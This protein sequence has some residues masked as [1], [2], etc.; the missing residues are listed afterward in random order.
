MTL[1]REFTLVKTPVGGLRLAQKPITGDVFGE[2][3]ESD[4][5]PGELFRL[6]VR[7]EGAG[8]VTLKNSAGESFTFGVNDKNEMFI[9]RSNAGQKDFKEEFGTDWFSKYAV[10]RLYEGGWEMDLIFDHCLT[11]LYIDGGSR[12]LTNLVFPTAAYDKI[13]TDGS[14]KVLVHTG[15]A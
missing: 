15:N 5:I 10:A 2:G 6:T 14:A 13:E 9:D 4:T 3:K 12:V 7:G 8:S 11:E 1:A